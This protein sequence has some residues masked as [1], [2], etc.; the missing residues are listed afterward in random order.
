M[1]ETA[2]STTSATIN[3]SGEVLRHAFACKWINWLDPT[4]EGITIPLFKR[5]NWTYHRKV[6]MILVTT[7]VAAAAG[8]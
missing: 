6:M 3:S 8:Y 7:V 1:T 2:H 4:K 5:Q